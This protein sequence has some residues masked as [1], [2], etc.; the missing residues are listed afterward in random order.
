METPEQTVSGQPQAREGQTITPAQ[1]KAL[2]AAL[3]PSF[4][5]Y[6]TLQERMEYLNQQNINLQKE[7]GG[8]PRKAALWA[9]GGGLAGGGLGYWFSRPLGRSWK[10]AIPILS[11][12]GTAVVSMVYTTRRLMR[13]LATRNEALQ[14]EAQQI[15]VRMQELENDVQRIGMEVLM[16]GQK[17]HHEEHA[18]EA[19][20]KAEMKPEV[21]MGEKKPEA[22]TAE[23][24]A[25]KTA[26]EKKPTAVERVAAAGQRSF[27]D[28]AADKTALQR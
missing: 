4:Q 8:I 27:Q 3:A 14:N 16:K 22:A 1:A 9:G 20:A 23:P 11:A 21:I 18:Q 28:M 5:E 25:G 17:L 13:P 12:L 19:A 10:I 6:Q 24:P 15:A 26:A 7:A 2:E